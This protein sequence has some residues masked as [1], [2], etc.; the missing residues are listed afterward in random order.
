MHRVELKAGIVLC[1][2]ISLLGFV[3][4]APCGVESKLSLQ[5]VNEHSLVPNA[6]CGVESLSFLALTFFSTKMVP[7]APC[8]VE[9]LSFLALT[10]FSTKMV[11]NA[12]CGVERNS[13]ICLRSLQLRS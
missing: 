2:D 13:K 7:N 5:V 3:P 11:P 6:P 1:M 8:G 4:N 12:P 10:F 9:S